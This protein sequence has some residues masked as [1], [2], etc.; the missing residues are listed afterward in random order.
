M[1]H[2]SGMQAKTVDTMTNLYGVSVKI[3]S[4]KLIL[5]SCKYVQCKKKTSNSMQFLL[6]FFICLQYH[7]QAYFAPT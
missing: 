2:E 3:H 5:T 1:S 4:D 7:L 6:E